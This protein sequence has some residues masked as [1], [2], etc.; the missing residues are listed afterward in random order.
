[1]DPRGYKLTQD[2]VIE[3]N[4]FKGSAMKMTQVLMWRLHVSVVLD[5]PHG[6]Q[7]ISFSLY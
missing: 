5:A 1:M 3:E 6:S 7:T 4:M 2:A